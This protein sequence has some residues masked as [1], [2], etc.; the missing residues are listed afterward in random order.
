M[1]SWMTKG[2]LLESILY[3]QRRAL[4]AEKHIDA[5]EDYSDELEMHINMLTNEIDEV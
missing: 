3:W 1:E 4:K 2:E 5:M